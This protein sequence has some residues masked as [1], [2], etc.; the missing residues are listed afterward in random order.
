MGRA[1]FFEDSESIR[2]IRLDIGW[3]W[4]LCRD[5]RTMEGAVHGRRISH[6][7]VPRLPVAAY[8]LE[9]FSDMSGKALGGYWFGTSLWCY[10]PIPPWVTLDK[11]LRHE[12][13][14]ISSGHAEAAGILL[15]IL[16]FLPIWAAQ[17]PLRS[18]G[19]PVCVHSDSDVAVK[20]WNGLTGRERLRPYLR[21]LE[22]LCAFYNIQLHVVFVPGKDNEI[23]D[24]ISRQDGVMTPEL[25][26]LFPAGEEAPLP[27]ISP[28]LL[29]L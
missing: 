11:N 20:C 14:F 16:S 1:T 15:C 21:V 6:V 7:G 13:D 23:A 22:R 5:Y 27:G 17:H 2:R 9:I 4:S 10:A 24:L 19:E 26:R 18:P 29:F 25:R 3:W 12:K 8:T 28:N